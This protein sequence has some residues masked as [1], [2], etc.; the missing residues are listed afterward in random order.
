GEKRTSVSA[1]LAMHTLGVSALIAGLNGGQHQRATLAEAAER[2][3]YQS[4]C[5]PD[6][7]EAE[8]LKSPPFGFGKSRASTSSNVTGVFGVS[9]TGGFGVWTAVLAIEFSFR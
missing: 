7:D 1:F 8:S 3:K 6:G 4:C 5:R 2:R 9:T